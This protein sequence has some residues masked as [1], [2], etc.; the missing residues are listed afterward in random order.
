MTYR[1][2]QNCTHWSSTCR[3]TFKHKG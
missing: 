1:V 3:S 2:S